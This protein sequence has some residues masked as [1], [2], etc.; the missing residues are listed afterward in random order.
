MSP[1]QLHSLFVHKVLVRLF[2]NLATVL[3]GSIS[4]LTQNK[5]ESM[6]WV[7]G[8]QLNMPFENWKFKKWKAKYSRAIYLMLNTRAKCMI[9]LE[10]SILFGR[11]HGDIK[12]Y[13]TVH[14]TSCVVCCFNST[15]CTIFSCTPNLLED[16]YL[17]SHATPGLQEKYTRSISVSHT[18]LRQHTKITKYLSQRFFI[19]S[20]VGGFY[21]LIL[22]F[23]RLCMK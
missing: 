1:D 13:C 2:N 3:W 15:Y 5:T 20:S 11:F 7:M 10:S 8:T 12:P 22:I 6:D 4:S 16:K 23:V 14:I 9:I 17:L 18:R 21:G 19:S